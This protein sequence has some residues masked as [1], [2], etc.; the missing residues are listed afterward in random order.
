MKYL[1]PLVGSESTEGAE[2]VEAAADEAGEGGDGLEHD[3]SVDVAV[4]EVE[5]SDSEEEVAGSGGDLV[6]HGLGGV[7]RLG[8]PVL[9]EDVQVLSVAGDVLRMENR[10]EGILWW[11]RRGTPCLVCSRGPHRGHSCR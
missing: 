11:R 5:I 4:S 7:G 10:R 9:L 2:V 3:G 8:T 6:A 1:D